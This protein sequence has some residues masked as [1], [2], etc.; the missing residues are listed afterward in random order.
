MGFHK[1]VLLAATCCAFGSGAWAQ[2]AVSA[3]TVLARVNGEA[4]TLGHMLLVRESLPNEYKSL[5]DRQ[6]FDGILEQLVQQTILSQKSPSPDSLQIRLTLEN[7]RRLMR[8]A[9]M[10]EQWSEQPISEGAIQDA[11]EAAYSGVD[12]GL[13]YKAAHILVETETAALELIDKV[14]AGE[15]FAALARDFSTGPSGPRGGDLGWF[16]KGMMVPPFEQ[17]VIELEVGEV[18]KP[19]KTD[20]GWHVILLNETR[21]VESPALEDVR[22]MIVEDLRRAAV[23]AEMAVLRSQA[24]IELIEDPQI[25]PGAVKNF[26]LLSQ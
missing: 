5:P 24:D 15:E 4:I 10:I 18:S 6:L 22:E 11:Y 20:F 21:A 8:A 2:E 7:D 26:E 1:L 16:G 9:R 23:E 25:D 17:A 14:N 19:V 12:Q 13:E 3:E